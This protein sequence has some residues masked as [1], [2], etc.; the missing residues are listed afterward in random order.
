[1]N[2]L[3][4]LPVLALALA[5]STITATASFAHEG[6][7]V[8]GA[9]QAEHGGVIKPAGEVYLE[10][11]TDKSGTL[12]L[13]AMDHDKQPVA[14]EEIQIDATAQLPRAKAKTPVKFASQKLPDA[15]ASHY[16]GS[17]DAK[18]AHRYT[19]EV[20][21]SYQGKKEK[22]RFQVEPKR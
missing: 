16:A 2:K 14:L 10:L 15:H 17:F 8:P 7:A 1:M 21:A 18:G 5:I 6:H 19:L 12:R 9:A 11:V 4:L 20:T 13:F 22:A 3:P